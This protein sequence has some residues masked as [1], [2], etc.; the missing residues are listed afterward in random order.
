MKKVA[1]IGYGYVGKGMHKIFPNALIFD[2]FYKESAS[3]E[4]IN[5]ECGLA[6][7]CVPT[8]PLGMGEQKVNPDEKVFLPADLSIVRESISWLE[9]EFILI[10]STVPPTTTETLRKE[11]GKKICFSP[12]YIGEGNYYVP[13]HYPDPLDPRKHDFLIVGGD[14]DDCVDILAYFYKEMGPAKKYLVC[15]SVEAELVKY[16]ENT[17]GATK[18][19]FCNEWYDICKQFGGA[20]EIVRE[21]FLMDSRVEPM[22]TAVFKDKRGFSGK[23]FPKDLLAIVAQCE[24]KGY[25]PELLKQVWEVNKQMLNKNK[26]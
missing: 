5:Q 17:W 3:K 11:F 25:T 9:T 20:Y 16:M 7:V 13:P 6:I 8:A 4:Q 24:A 18:V 19:T 12:E 2:P 15:S 22:H 1:I 23:C 26:E 21:G 10:K 14:K